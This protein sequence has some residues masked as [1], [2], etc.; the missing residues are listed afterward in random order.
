MSFATERFL[1]D[2][3]GR[4]A[5]AGIPLVYATGN[6]DPGRDAQRT[7]PLAWP[8]NVELI[9]DGHPAAHRLIR[10]RDGREVGH[11]TAAG[12]ASRRETADLAAA[13]PPCATRESPQI[14]LLHTQV[15][16][17]LVR[18]ADDHEPYAPCDLPGCWRADTTT[19]RS[20]TCTSGSASRRRRRC[21]TPATPR[22]G[23]TARAARGAAAR[24]RGARRA[25]PASSSVRSD[26][27]GSK[28]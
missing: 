9:G 7:R 22:G 25:R 20:A 11:V 15:V 6:H 8:P 24:G 2:E 12:H 23:R 26:P 5:D 14:A 1:V 10:D 21:T 17:S 16:G 28:P 19:G 27:S 18:A 4:L 3:L 13:F